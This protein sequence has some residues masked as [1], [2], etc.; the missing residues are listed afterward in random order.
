[1]AGS[2]IRI[3]DSEGLPPEAA[4]RGDAGMVRAARASLDGHRTGLARVLPFLGPAFIACVAYIDP[5]NFATNIQGGAQFGY[6][7]L[8]VITAANLM[9]AFLQM[10]SAKLGIATDNNLPALCHQHLSP[11]MNLGLWIVSEVAAMATDV[12]EF[13]GAALGLYLL[14]HIPLLPAALLTGVITFAILGLQ[15]HG[16]R[17]LEIVITA[18]VGVIA[19][20]YLLETI[21][22]HPNAGQ[23]AYHAVVPALSGSSLFLA[24]GILGA[25]IMPHVLYLHSALVQGRVPA[26]TPRDRMRIFAMERID[27]VIAMTLA[28]LVNGAMMFMAAAV[29]H[30]HG[31][32]DVADLTVAFHT[33]TPLLG[34]AAS[35]IFGV[36]LLASGLSSSTVGTLAG[37]VIMRGFLGWSIPVWLRRVLTMA[38]ALLIIALNINPTQ[39]IIFTQVILSFALVAPIATLL[40]FTARRD[41]MGAMVNQRRTTVIGLACG[42]VILALNAVLLAQVLGAI[43]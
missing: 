40:Y 29:F 38:P 19:G 23:I 3:V 10:L 16:F 8:W 14:F 25:T 35:I 15:Q 31:R 41:V 18:L 30:A 20:A 13:T 5:G 2:D 37:Q 12:A 7:L 1:M 6:E 39:V 43:H 28:G 42:A 32:A 24:V 9:A 21:L 33:L 34:S 17:T 26:R 22:S 27:I 11:R 4:R 36:S